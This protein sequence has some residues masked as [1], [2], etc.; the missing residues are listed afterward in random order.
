MTNATTSVRRTE[1][2][3]VVGGAA[4]L[5]ALV[6]VGWAFFTPTPRAQV[7]ADGTGVVPGA[8]IDH[9]FDGVGVFSM[10]MLGVGVIVGLLSWWGARSWRGPVGAISAIVAA[11]LA[12]GLAIGIGTWVLDLRLSDRSGL[13]AGDTFDVAPNIWF[14]AEVTGAVSAPGLLLIIAPLLSAFV[15]LCAVL[16]SRSADLGQSGV[17]SAESTS[18]PT[19]T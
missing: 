8:Q 9:Y 5:G 16:M 2:V 3:R 10:L 13:R 6:G 18:L 4:V 1:M 12:G 17:P 7:L 19:P 11:V 14:N 15:Y